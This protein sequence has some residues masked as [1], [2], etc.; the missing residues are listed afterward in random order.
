MHVIPDCLVM[1]IEEFEFDSTNDKIDTTI[2]ILYDQKMKHYVIR[3]K[4]RD[5]DKHPAVEYSFNCTKAGDLESFLSFI[6]CKKNYWSSSLYNY[7]NLPYYSNN[8]SYDFLQKHAST[9][10][11]ISGYDK[12]LYSKKEL[13]KNLK[14]LKNVFNNYN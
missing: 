8:I 9:E 6:I 2:Y 4:R 11:E 1:K 13:I 12:Q 7:D 5:T 10:Y 14:M 3:G